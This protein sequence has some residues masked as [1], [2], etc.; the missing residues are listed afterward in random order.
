MDFG[1]TVWVVYDTGWKAIR[2]CGGNSLP[3]IFETKEEADEM[4]E[5]LSFLE[6]EECVLLKKND[7]NRFF[8]IV[9]NG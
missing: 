5:G 8:S 6:V 1:K 3:L 2:E 9:F 4:I 7:L